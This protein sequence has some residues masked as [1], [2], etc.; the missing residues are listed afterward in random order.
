MIAV[1]ETEAC[2]GQKC[3]DRL[4]NTELSQ[5]LRLAVKVVIQWKK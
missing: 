3:G 5:V 1:K 2:H 4:M